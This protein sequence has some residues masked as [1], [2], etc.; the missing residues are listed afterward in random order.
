MLVLAS[1]LCL[2]DV[3]VDSFH[4]FVCY[5]LSVHN[6]RINVVILVMARYYL[7]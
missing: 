3:D 6:N 2:V 5:I 7:Y 4:V 1:R